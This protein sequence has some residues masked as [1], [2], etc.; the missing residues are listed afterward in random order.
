MSY[1]LLV[2]GPRGSRMRRALVEAMRTVYAENVERYDPDDLGDN[3]M[4]FAVSVV[5]NLR[6]FA[7][8]VVEPIEGVEAH[9][10]HNSFWLLID[11]ERPLYLYKA[12]PGTLSVDSMRFDESDLRQQI[13]QRNASHLQL[14][15]DVCQAG[16]APEEDQLPPYAV[17]VHFGDPEGAF[18]HA[19]I[20][21]PYRIA[22][23]S[24]LWAWLQPFEAEPDELH[25]QRPAAPPE[26][27][28]P[29][30]DS[31]GLGLRLRPA[32][33]RASEDDS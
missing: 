4:T 31:D 24:C 12:P 17:I 6:H 3:N 29:R 23:G 2:P 30:H 8:R 5:H 18:S 9:R 10:G 21:A 28:P 27:V 22:D 15:L 26:P 20:G 25:G 11:R 1:E 13:T 14:Q 16:T 19:V 7:E 33:E 32:E